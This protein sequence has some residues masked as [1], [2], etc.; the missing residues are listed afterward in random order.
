[1]DSFFKQVRKTE[2]EARR[3]KY[4]A[5]TLPFI[6]LVIL[7]FVNMIGWDT[8]YQKLIIVVVV[9][10]FSVSIFWWWWA[11][12]R[13]CHVIQQLHNTEKRLTEVKSEIVKTR[14]SLKDL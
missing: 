4:A 12:D 11:L 13:I 3:W 5:W 10:F 7:L 8:L 2:N 9:A 1:M 14:D 6:A